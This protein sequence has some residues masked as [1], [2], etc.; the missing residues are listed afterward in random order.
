MGEN[1][2]TSV[3]TVPV[4]DGDDPVIVID[5]P[6]DGIKGKAYTLPEIT[7]KDYSQIG[8]KTVGLYKS[9]C[10]GYC[11]QREHADGGLY[12]RYASCGRSV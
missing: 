8:E 6:K 5:K 11:G 12:R 10:K 1:K 7:F 3:V 2:I 9:V 4:Y